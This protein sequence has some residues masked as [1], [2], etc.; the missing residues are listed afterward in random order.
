MYYILLALISTNIS[1][2]IRDP[3]LNNIA[4]KTYKAEEFKYLYS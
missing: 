4:L 3:R 1:F 2:S